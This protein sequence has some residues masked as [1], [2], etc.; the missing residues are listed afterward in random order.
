MTTVEN[1]DPGPAGPEHEVPFAPLPHRR[2]PPRNAASPVRT[3]RRPRLGL[4]KPRGERR[5]AIP[6]GNLS[7][8]RGR[9]TTAASSDREA[10]DAQEAPVTAEPAAPESAPAAAGMTAAAQRGPGRRVALLAGIVTA[11]FVVIGVIGYV[12]AGSGRV[13]VGGVPVTNATLPAKVNGLAAVPGAQDF[14]NQPAWKQRVTEAVGKDV[15]VTA[16]QYGSLSDRRYIRVV[17][18]PTDLTG[19]LQLTWAADQ[20]T[21]VGDY[22]C[23]QNFALTP[24]A[25]PTVRPTMIICW[26]TTAEFSAYALL[27]DFD[28]TPLAS[29]AIAA[30]KPIWSSR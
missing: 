25:K 24:G 23:T 29:Q 6:P 7:L 1:P 14:S 18:A 22:R 28:H 26:R 17:F 30:L 20:G 27:V 16:R 9:T 13:G 10:T 2:H 12:V 5:E 19:K 3:A 11:V 21:T 8:P 4:P 15:P